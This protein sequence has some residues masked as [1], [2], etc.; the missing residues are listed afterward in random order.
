M[1]IT[2]QQLFECLSSVSHS[3]QIVI[4]DPEIAEILKAVAHVEFDAELNIHKVCTREYHEW[5]KEDESKHDE[6]IKELE[7]RAA[8]AERKSQ[9]INP[10]KAKILEQIQTLRAVGNSAGADALELIAKEL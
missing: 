10:A 9:P 8:I 4:C 3:A 6:Y 5:R 1:N 2:A 7:I